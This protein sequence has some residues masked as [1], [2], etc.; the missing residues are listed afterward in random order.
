MPLGTASVIY[1]VPKHDYLFRGY[2]YVTDKHSDVMCLTETWLSGTDA[3]NVAV[4]SLT[5]TLKGYNFISRPQKSRNGG[6]VAVLVRKTIKSKL[7]CGLKFKTFGYLDVSL[8]SNMVRLVLIYRPPPSRANGFTVNGFMG[9]FSSLLE[10]LALAPGRLLLTGD[11]NFNLDDASSKEATN[12][13]QL[14][15]SQNLRQHIQTQ[16]HLKGHTLDLLITRNQDNLIQAIDL[17]DDMPSDH[18][19]IS[20]VLRFKAASPVKK[21][22]QSRALHKL[23]IDNF[24]QSIVASELMS[25]SRD[26]S[27]CEEYNAILTGI[28]DQ[29]APIKTRTIK[30][31][32]N[33]PWFSEDLHAAKLQKRKYERIWKHSGL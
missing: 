14:L 31:R 24:K 13:L 26:E 11:F 20:T 23:D 25:P 18:C 4:G 17:I 6:G 1:F 33:A 5:S 30:E 28:L 21:R 10:Q 22:I 9:E 7:N 8:G 27:L 32:P 2:I 15:N 16:T 12:F 19:A 29:L 3:D